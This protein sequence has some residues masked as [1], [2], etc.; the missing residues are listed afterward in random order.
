MGSTEVSSPL[1]GPGGQH[2]TSE[3]WGVLPPFGNSHTPR[4]IHHIQ[5]MQ[6]LKMALNFVNNIAWNVHSQ[7]REIFSNAFRGNFSATF[8]RTSGAPREETTRDRSPDTG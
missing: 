5:F 6:I 3:Q 4:V 2:G 1:H 8:T 7:L